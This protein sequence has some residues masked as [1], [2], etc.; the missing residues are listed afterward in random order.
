M[1][2][3]VTPALADVPFHLHPKFASDNT[4]SSILIITTVTCCASDSCYM[5]DCVHIINY[6]II[7]INAH[8]TEYCFE[9][10]TSVS[11]IKY[12]LHSN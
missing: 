9:L 2:V 4:V 1:S 5:L 6:R 12:V 11:L 8:Y 3:C 10:G 7:I